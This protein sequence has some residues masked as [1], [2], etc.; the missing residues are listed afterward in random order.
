MDTYAIIKNDN[1]TVVNIV[2]WDG[3]PAKWKPE[4]GFTVTAIPP[5]KFVE[6]GMIFT[7]D[8]FLPPV[9]TRT[10]DEAKEKA[11]KSIDE[12][13]VSL[14]RQGFEYSNK[15]FSLSN[16]AQSYW[17]GLGNLI[18][19]KLLLDG[20]FP[21]RI[22]TIDDIDIYDIKD[23]DDALMIFATAAAKV[24]SHLTSGTALKD[25]IREASTIKEI[26]LIIDLR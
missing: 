3:D 22:N 19:N 20:D 16:H 25:K 23:T 6:I 7:N 10:I 12:K 4:T 15:I 24:K 8:E 1:S 9:D 17:N 14:I 5:N 2:K 13:T 21:L 26:D 11:F 18:S